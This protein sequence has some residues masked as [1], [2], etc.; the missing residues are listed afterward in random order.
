MGEQR[1]LKVTGG[2]VLFAFFS[3]VALVLTSPA[4]VVYDE[5]PFMKYVAPAL[6]FWELACGAGRRIYH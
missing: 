5:P 4:E 3:L 6:S 2:L 1:A